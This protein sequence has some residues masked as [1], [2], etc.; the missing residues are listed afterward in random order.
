MIPIFT[1]FD[2]REEVGTHVFQ[3]SVLHNATHPVAFIPLRIELFRDYFGDKRG[4]N[5]FTFTRFLIPWLQD[6][7]GWAIFA[8]AAD[9]LCR[10]DIAELWALR[11]DYKAVQVVQHEYTTRHPRKY[12]GTPMECDNLDYPR[13]NWASLMLVNC[14]HFWWRQMRPEVIEGMSPMRLLRFEFLRDDLIGAL[15]ADWNW[16]AD[17]HGERADAKLLHWTT[18][19]AGFDSYKDAPHADEW[20]AA[21]E[22][23]Q[24]VCHG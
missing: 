17:E 3:S 6:F 4:S 11:D 2:E 7:R 20:R 24:S 9:M 21:R 18:G 16:L 19:I 14:S 23:M 12:V 13:K 5:A 15:P 8:D 22:R 1:G 10:A